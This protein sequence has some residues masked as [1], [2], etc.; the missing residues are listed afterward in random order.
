VQI[1]RNTEKTLRAPSMLH[2]ALSYVILLPSIALRLQ[3]RFP[4]HLDFPTPTTPVRFD[5]RHIQAQA[6]RLV[7]VCSALGQ[8]HSMVLPLRFLLASLLTCS[9]SLHYIRAWLY[10]LHSLTY[11][12]TVSTLP[13][14]SKHCPLQNP[15]PLSETLLYLVYALINNHFHAIQLS[16]A[17]AIAPNTS[18]PPK[19]GLLHSGFLPNP[20]GGSFRLQVS[21]SFSQTFR[22]WSLF[23]PSSLLRFYEEVHYFSPNQLGR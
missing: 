7:T 16:P 5:K 15:P 22:Y 8:V 4:F 18:T 9:Q 17:F 3:R 13:S 14:H 10:F 12:N 21:I 20:K 23:P 1:L 19:P 2:F 6:E 11:A